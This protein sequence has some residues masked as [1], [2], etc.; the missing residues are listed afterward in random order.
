MPKKYVL[1]NKVWDE[2]KLNRLA[3][4]IQDNA[5]EDRAKSEMLYQRAIEAMDNLDDGTLDG[6]TKL[7]TT[8]TQAL[9]QMGIANERLLKLA[10][11]LQKH[12]FK[13]MDIDAK[14]PE[15]QDL[16]MSL[17]EQLKKLSSK[18]DA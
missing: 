17:H 9:N 11:M 2:D 3:K 7:I 1:K 15:A 16:S 8:C 6:F 4:K 5:S 12:A 10:G 13:V 14:S 18:R